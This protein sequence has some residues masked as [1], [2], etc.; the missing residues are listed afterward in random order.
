[1]VAKCGRRSS[2]FVKERSEVGAA[3]QGKLGKAALFEQG[4]RVGNGAGR[5]NCDD[6]AWHESVDHQLLV[7]GCNPSGGWRVQLV[8]CHATDIQATVAAHVRDQQCG[9]LARSRVSHAYALPAQSLSHG[10]Q[11]GGAVGRLQREV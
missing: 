1:M 5:A 11:H 6:L 8:K 7:A 9:G 10:S 3:W 2:F 4:S